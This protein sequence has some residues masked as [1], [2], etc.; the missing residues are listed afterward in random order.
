M[1]GEKKIV[2]V[3][4]NQKQPAYIGTVLFSRKRNAF[5]LSLKDLTV[6]Y[7]LFCCQLLYKNLTY[8]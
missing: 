2:D 8:L 7:S 5:Y 1:L 4:R 6:S 3:L